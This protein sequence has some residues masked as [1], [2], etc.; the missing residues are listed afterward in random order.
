MR[1]W[2]SR[3]IAWTTKPGRN[4]GMGGSIC[5]PLA[6]TDRR[7]S[8]LLDIRRG[9]IDF[10][11]GT[12]QNRGRQVI[13]L[14]RLDFGGQPHRNPDGMDI[15]SPH[16]H[17]YKAGYGDKWAFPL[18]SDKFTATKPWDLLSEFLKFCNVIDPPMID[19]GLFA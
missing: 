18:P 10:A 3:S 2:P 14:A 12:Y 9:R 1:C 13:V 11:K 17:I 7:E 8:F 4:P 16:L 6:S 5:V 19:R 15:P